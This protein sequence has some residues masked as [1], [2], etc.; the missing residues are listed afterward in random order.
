MLCFVLRFYAF[1]LNRKAG[2]TD[3]VDMN[4]KDSRQFDQLSFGFNSDGVGSALREGVSL[5]KFVDKNIRLECAHH[6]PRQDVLTQG[7][8]LDSLPEMGQA[9]GTGLSESF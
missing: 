4:F 2:D 6:C 3:T 8:S 5:K 7:F 9:S 1:C